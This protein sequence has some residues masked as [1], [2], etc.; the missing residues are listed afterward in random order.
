AILAPSGYQFPPAGPDP[1]RT[2]VMPWDRGS[3]PAI[4]TIAKTRHTPSRPTRNLSNI[5]APHILADR[6]L[7]LVIE[8]RSGATHPLREHGCAA[9]PESPEDRRPSVAGGQIRLGGQLV[10]HLPFPLFPLFPLQD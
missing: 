5:R 2:N 9:P 1:T 4:T 3:Q 6:C 8:P 7:S 10:H